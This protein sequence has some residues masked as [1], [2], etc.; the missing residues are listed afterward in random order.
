M[1][2]VRDAFFAYNML[3]DADKRQA[4]HE[5]LKRIIKL[6]GGK[7]HKPKRGRK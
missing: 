6:C 2:D 5:N 3:S 7:K 1:I 4:N